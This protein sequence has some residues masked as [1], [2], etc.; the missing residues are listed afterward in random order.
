MSK[1]R[2]FIS[3]LMSTSKQQADTRRME[4]I[5]E[6]K[7]VE[8]EVINLAMTPERREEMVRL[9]GI[10]VVPQL[11]IGDEFIGNGDTVQ[12]LEDAGLLDQKLT[13]AN[14]PRRS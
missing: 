11:F 6:A 3:T 9:S 2:L 12:E 7:R 10:K 13:A 1:V 8:F 4:S 5:L 14:V